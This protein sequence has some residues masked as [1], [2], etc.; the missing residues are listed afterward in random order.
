MS[1][2]NHLGN[3]CKMSEHPQPDF[4]AYEEGYDRIFGKRN[5]DN[6]VRAVEFSRHKKRENS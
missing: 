6:N 2:C 1:R 3:K 5:T 4:K